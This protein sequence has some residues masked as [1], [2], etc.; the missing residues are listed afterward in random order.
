M[1]LSEAVDLVGR[2]IGAYPNG[3]AG[4]G[5]NYIGAIAGVFCD[6]PRQVATEC[7]SP[8]HGV[9]RNCTFLPTVADVVAWCEPALEALKQKELAATPHRSHWEALEAKARERAETEKRYLGD[10][11]LKPKLGA[12]VSELK[13]IY[14]IRAIPAGWDAVDLLHAKARLGAGFH[15]EVERL[16][17]T[18]TAAPPSIFAKVAENA[19]KAAVQSG[20]IT[21]D[22]LR[23]QYGARHDDPSPNYDTLEEKRMD[24]EPAP[25]HSNS[26]DGVPF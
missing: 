14:G 12:L 25:A 15:D 17:L 2:M 26:A 11:E 23:R 18:Q 10:R 1:N 8:I 6:Y 19:G 24:L 5:D 7:A 22:D 16:L 21:D 13:Q 20:H 9:A 3:G 4:A